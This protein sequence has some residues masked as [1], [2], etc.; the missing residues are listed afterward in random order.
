MGEILGAVI[1]ADNPYLK[2]TFNL[3]PL[4]ILA[5]GDISKIGQIVIDEEQGKA[6][7][8]LENVNAEAYY[9]HFAEVLSD[10][11]QSA[12]IG[13]FQE[14]KRIWSTPPNLTKV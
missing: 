12:V 1:L 3:K 13:S 9:A 14:Q 11:R 4:K 5:E 6:V 2:Q 10:H 8:I 7:K